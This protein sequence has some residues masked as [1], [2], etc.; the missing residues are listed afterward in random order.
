MRE[1]SSGNG[2][3]ERGDA[4]AV[5]D[6]IREATMCDA[7]ARVLVP[8][9]RR[10][11]LARLVEASLSSVSLEGCRPRRWAPRCYARELGR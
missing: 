10:G 5:S 1:V 11:A 2:G 9:C 6:P 3:E 4:T 8:A 7:T